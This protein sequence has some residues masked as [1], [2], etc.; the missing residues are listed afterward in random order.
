MIKNNAIL[1]QLNEPKQKISG[2]NNKAKSSLP[3]IIE[4]DSNQSINDSKDE[5]RSKPDL[6]D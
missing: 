2:S 3:V 6:N 1:L 5:L 4:E